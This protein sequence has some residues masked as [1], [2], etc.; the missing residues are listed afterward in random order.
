YGLQGAYAASALQQLL[1]QRRLEAMK[2]EQM[3]R[4]Q[5]QQQ[6]QNNRLTQ[7]DARNA[8]LDAEVSDLTAYDLQVGQDP[9]PERAETPSFGSQPIRGLRA[10]PGYMPPPEGVVPGAGG[11]PAPE[12]LEAGGMGTSP[13]RYKPM[14]IRLRSGDTIQARPQSRDELMQKAGDERRMDLR[15]YVTKQYAAREAEAAYAQPET[16]KQLSIEDQLADPN[17]APERRATLIRMLRDIA[18]AK[19]APVEPKEAGPKASPYSIERMDRVL[20]AVDEIIPQVSRWTTG[21][22]SYLSRLPETDARSFA[23]QLDTLKSNIMMNELVSMREASKTGGALGQVSDREGTL[24]Q[25]AL[26]ALD[27]GQSPSD[28]VVQLKKVR[29]SVERWRNAV[30]SEG[31]GLPGVAIDAKEPGEPKDGDQREIPGF[32]GSLAEFRGGKWIRIK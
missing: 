27:P 17:I 22:G 32:P 4:E 23:S 10:L 2:Q 26:G 18:G 8:R 24:L 28:L 13:L 5:A 6:F 16:P 7:N 15:D 3:A 20:Q 1:T 11:V 9:G 30:A 21:V 29:D 19:R 25:S 31:L 12:G 14:D